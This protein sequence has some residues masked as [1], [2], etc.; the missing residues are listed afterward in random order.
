MRERETRA[1]MGGELR[2]VVARAEQIDRR[3]RDVG[4]HGAHVAER[5]IVGE[6]ALLEQ[7][8]L[9]KSVEEIVSRRIV[10]AAV[11]TDVVGAFDPDRERTARP[12]AA[13]T[14]T[15]IPTIARRRGQAVEGSGRMKSS[16][17]KTVLSWL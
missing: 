15:R 13:T 14:R 2:A 8:Q 10:L 6:A 16:V 1:D 3:Q 5:M 17:P 11:A 4:R 9:L 7:Q 12:T